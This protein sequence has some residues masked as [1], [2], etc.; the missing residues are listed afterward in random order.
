MMTIPMSEPDITR[1][2]RA[3]VLEVLRSPT[4]S[5]GP[6]LELFERALASY[7]GT[8]HAIGISNGTAGL[9]LAMIA[10]GVGEG[11][12]VLTTPF[13]FVASANCALY[14]GAR[15]EFVDVDPLSLT[16]DPGLL[17]DAAERLARAGR[18]AKAIVPVHVFGQPA[19]MDPICAIA[20]RHHMAVVEDACEAIG[21]R[22]RGRAVG[23]LG[24]AA[25]FAF[26]PNKQMTTGEGGMLVTDNADWSALFR[27]L[28][29]QGRDVFD[30]W[31]AHTRL[32][33]NYRLDEL[34]AALG[35]VQI[36]RL[37]EILEKRERVADWYSERLIG[38]EGL[39]LPTVA[40]WTTRLSWFVYVVRIEGAG[41][42][43]RLIAELLRHGVP[44][45]PYFPPIHLQPFYQERFGFRRGMFPVAEAAGDSCLALPFFGTM[46]EGQVDYVC[47]MLTQ[48][49]RQG[50]AQ[51][52]QAVA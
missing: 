24:D 16:I 35:A 47:N 51:R 5:I 17:A 20:T 41:E 26:Y 21:A 27:S 52:V 39:Q 13:S 31:L 30:G 23:R 34:S 6:R 46:R 42:R 32:G 50:P 12:T 19:D 22:Y 7:I 25:V 40:S 38:L 4:L 10:A 11:D 14:V 29:N 43:D 9:H 36:M 44:A 3:A 45:R 8:R 33:Y 28:R 48:C 15:P 18:P 49:M 1:A 2:E 37:E